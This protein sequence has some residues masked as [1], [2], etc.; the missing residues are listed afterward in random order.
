MN[1]INLA[2]SAAALLELDARIH[3][4]GVLAEDDDVDLFRMFHRTGDALVVLDGPHTCIKVKQLAQ[5]NIQ[6][7][8]PSAHRRRQWSLDGNAQ[9]P[10]GAD[11]VVRKPGVEL[12]KRL[13]ARENLEPR[14]LALA[15][16]GFF[17]R[18]VKN[19]LRSLPDVAAGAVA[20]DKWNDGIVG[21]LILAVVVLDRLA[22]LRQFQPVVGLLHLFSGVPSL[23]RVQRKANTCNLQVAIS[24]ESRKVTQN[25]VRVHF[26]TRSAPCMNIFY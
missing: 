16:I 25:H 18:C 4:L 6:G 13:F 19:A 9:V 3:V 22:V 24:H 7:P 26:R 5:S 23:D 8:N 14:D 17:D 20:F 12:A 1:S 10:R 2:T 15:A 11:G 21:N